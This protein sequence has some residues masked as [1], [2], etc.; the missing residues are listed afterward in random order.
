MADEFGYKVDIISYC[1]QSEHA[2]EQFGSW[3]TSYNNSFGSIRKSVK[4]KDYPDIT[5]V[6]NF[7]PGAEVFV[8]WLEWSSGD[9]FGQGYCNNVAEVAVF[10]N[11]QDAGKLKDLIENPVYQQKDPEF[12]A[13]IIP[14][15]SQDGQILELYVGDWTG[16]FETLESVHI[17]HTTMGRAK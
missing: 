16:Y 4:K 5:S 6:I 13:G 3:S 10:N 11:M 7:A 8:V 1:Y 2:T 14:F 17:E 12:D 15:K 9:S